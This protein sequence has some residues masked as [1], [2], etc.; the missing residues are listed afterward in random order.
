MP[1]EN[2]KIPIADLTLE[3]VP[4]VRSISPS[5]CISGSRHAEMFHEKFVLAA[6]AL[7]GE[8]LIR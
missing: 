6:R 2:S 5:S 3:R 1:E 8:F 7:G 4:P